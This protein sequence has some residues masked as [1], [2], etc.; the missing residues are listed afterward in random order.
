M[1]GAFCL[2]GRLPGVSLAVELWG[3]AAAPT[4]PIAPKVRTESVSGGD[5]ARNVTISATPRTAGSV[6]SALRRTPSPR[7]GVPDQLR[8]AAWNNGEM[9]LDRVSLASDSLQT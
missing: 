4:V 1:P 2:V 5:A 6:G 8:E 7:G 3:R 9:D